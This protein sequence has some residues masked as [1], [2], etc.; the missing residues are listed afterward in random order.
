MILEIDAP[1][2]A[3]ETWDGGGGGGG[4]SSSSIPVDSDCDSVGGSGSTPFHSP[5]RKPLLPL[6]GRSKTPDR[7]K[8]FSKDVRKK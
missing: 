8:S 2:P 7:A 3:I 6:K 1:A 4:G 5:S